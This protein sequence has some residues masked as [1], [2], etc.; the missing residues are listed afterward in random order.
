MKVRGPQQIYAA[1]M[2]Q[3]LFK[4]TCM[5]SWKNYQT[6]VIIFVVILFLDDIFY[7]SS[8]IEN[9]KNNIHANLAVLNTSSINYCV[10][11]ILQYKRS[12]KPI[13]VIGQETELLE[14]LRNVNW[15]NCKNLSKIFVMSYQP[16]VDGLWFYIVMPF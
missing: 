15:S 16:I 4:I 2:K 5:T 9:E 13:V 1:G 12:W 7:L 6:T 10:I 3:N 8:V 14:K 11:H